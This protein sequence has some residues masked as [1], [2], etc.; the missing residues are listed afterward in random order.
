M[1]ANHI[2][3]I[4]S[5]FTA[6]AITALLFAAPNGLFAQNSP[7]TVVPSTGKVGIG[8]TNPTETLDVNGTVKASGF[9]GDG[10]KL[11]NLPTSSQW[12]T[13]HD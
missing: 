3:R 10:S 9:K 12:N 11:N 5:G 6:G 1:F 8:N 7:V 2:N 4:R 13:T